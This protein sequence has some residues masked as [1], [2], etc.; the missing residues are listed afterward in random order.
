MEGAKGNPYQSGG[1]GVMLLG[2]AQR[3]GSTSQT[4]TRIWINFRQ[5]FTSRK[6]INKILFIAHGSP[7]RG[8]KRGSGESM[9]ITRLQERGSRRKLSTYNETTGGTDL[10]T[11][12]S[13]KQDFP[14]VPSERERIPKEGEHGPKEKTRQV[15]RKSQRQ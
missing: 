11:N 7:G 5:G 12:P 9:W 13:G 14:T 10:P 6:V 3:Q 4:I 15:G 1:R 2:C 8:R